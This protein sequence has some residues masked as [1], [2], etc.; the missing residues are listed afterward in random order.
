M[1]KILNYT[2]EAPVSKTLAEIQAEL[3]RAKAN[4]IRTD[5]DGQGKII[6]IYFQIDV[7]GKKLPFRLP[8]KVDEA[9][10][11]MYEG[12]TS[13]EWRYKE[14]RMEQARRTAWRIVYTWLKAQI[15]LIELE[16]AKPEE[17]FLP[18]LVV[19]ANQTLFEK[20]RDNQFLLPSTK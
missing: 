12:K 3:V 7:E 2:S 8:A 1:K 18:Y 6:A 20:M 19:G 4:S 15:A 11:I 10:K 14:Q 5:Y 9:Y 17:I 16:Q 13:Q